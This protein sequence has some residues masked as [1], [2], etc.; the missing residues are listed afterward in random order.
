MN[1]KRFH[2]LPSQKNGLPLQEDALPGGGFT[3]PFRYI[4]CKA[5]LSAA[6]EVISTIDSDSILS[7][8]FA[9]GKMLGV[10]IVRNHQGETGY[11]CGFSGNV[12]GR[13]QIEG[14]VPPIFDLTNPDGHFKK[15]EAEISS[16]N[17]KIRLMESDPKLDSIL[18][19]LSSCETEAEKE[20]AAARA[21]MAEARRRRDSIRASY[22]RENI[23]ERDGNREDVE[24]IL[25]R[26]SQHEKAEFGRLK[27]RWKER[28]DTIKAAAKAITDEILGMK[29]VRREMSDQLQR[30]IFHQ[31]RVHNI[32]GQEA[33]IW[34]VFA[35]KGLV[36][37]GGTGDCAAPK[38][39]EYAFR[40]NL[41]PLAMGEFWYGTSPD[42]AVRVHGHFY[43]SCTSKCGPLLGYMMKGLHIQDDITFECDRKPAIM[44]YDKDIIVAVKP[45]GMPSVPGLDNR[46]SL[47]E[48]LSAETGG[49]VLA[50]HRLDMDTCGV[51]VFA[52]N[53]SS[54][55]FL[56][57]QFEKRTV[58][59]VYLARLCPG[60]IPQE[61][62]IALPLSPDYDE[63]PRQKVDM[64]NGKEAVTLYRIIEKYPDSSTLVEFRPL[65][66]RTHQLRIHSAHPLGLGCPIEGDLLYGGCSLSCA[67][68]TKLHLQA[69]SISFIHPGSRETLVFDM[70]IVT[71]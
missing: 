40:N 9:Q 5:V 69:K 65:T 27:K 68:V 23:D 22:S 49:E 31:Y 29:S 7:K 63:R 2:L 20:I 53:T 64:A 13:S 45:S 16:I 51:M 70:G 48:W 21:S 60:D 25:E 46:I 56:Q 8:D 3:N 54:Q 19:E 15:L 67:K 42:T 32:L 17:E 47:Q 14:F 18:H 36:P 41:Q 24:A 6:R 39:L 44:H 71:I 52:R 11:L 28:I 10:L 43:P 66:G 12:G 33:S 62:R 38:L 30:W 4:P 59:K 1:R 57:S 34:E 58:K 61:G 55:A 37:P 50:V 26:E 35:E